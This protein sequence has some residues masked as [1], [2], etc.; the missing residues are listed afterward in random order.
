[1]RHAMAV[2]FAEKSSSSD[3]RRVSPKG[4]LHEEIACAING[5]RAALEHTLSSRNVPKDLRCDVLA[6]VSRGAQ[7]L[8]ETRSAIRW[9]AGVGAV[10]SIAFFHLLNYPDHSQ[11]GQPYSGFLS[12]AVGINLVA[13]SIS[14]ALGKVCC[15]INEQ[16]WARKVTKMLSQGRS[17]SADPCPDGQAGQMAAQ[18]VFSE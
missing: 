16:I 2:A 15:R 5:D 7:K 17:P 1:M 12:L 3:K 8:S 6:D 13:S 11:S 14:F 18:T 4:V 10:L 9:T